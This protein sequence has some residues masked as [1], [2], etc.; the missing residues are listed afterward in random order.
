MRTKQIKID[1]VDILL[2]GTFG[3]FYSKINW[4]RLDVS[5]EDRDFTGGH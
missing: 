2:D 4:R 1:G 5:S 3:I